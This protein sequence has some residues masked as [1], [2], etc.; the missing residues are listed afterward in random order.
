M[1]CLQ[2]AWD[3]RLGNAWPVAVINLL[4]VI[5]LLYLLGASGTE[6]AGLL[7]MTCGHLAGAT[8]TS[9]T[10]SSRLGMEHP[11]AADSGEV[12]TCRGRDVVEA[13]AEAMLNEL[14]PE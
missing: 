14:G 11:G 12:K 10:K 13:G 9:G 1:G 4:S 2:H 3:V 7:V 6:Q 8:G 5:N